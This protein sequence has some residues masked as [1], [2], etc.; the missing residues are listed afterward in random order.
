MS[1]FEVV[2]VVLGSFP[3]ILNC[4]DYYREGFEPLEEWWNFRTHFIAFVDDIRHQMMIYHLSITAL[5]DPIISD[6]ASLNALLKDAN[7]ERWEKDKLKGMLKQRLVASEL[8]RFLRIVQ[9]MET[10]IL[11]LKKLLGIKDGDVRIQQDS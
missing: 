6:P 5:L 7:D 1:G 9:R 3:I 2:V 10:E 11:K 4:L 8:E